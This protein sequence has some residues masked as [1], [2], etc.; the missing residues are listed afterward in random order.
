ME[1]TE[2][3]TASY[4]VSELYK[5]SWELVKKNSKSLAVITLIGVA[6]NVAISSFAV[7]AIMNNLVDDVSSAVVSGIIGG[8]ISILAGLFVGLLQVIALKRATEG[9]AINA[10]GVVNESL[11][12]VPRA[13]SYGLFVVGIFIAAATLIAL[14]TAMAGVLGVLAGIAFFVMVIVALF[15][16]AFVQFLIVEPK[17]MSFME[18]FTVSEKLTKGVYNTIFLVALMSIVLSIAGGIVGGIVSSP[19]NQKAEVKQTNSVQYEFNNAQSVEDFRENFNKAVKENV[20]DQ[21]GVK[22]VIKQIITQSISWGIGLIVLG[23]LLGL[24]NKR[25]S[26]L[27]L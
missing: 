8:A 24:Y 27:H 3:T 23:A 11:K 1:S 15:R 22:Y 17:E 10:S 16:Y 12:F 4:S 7:F 2:H 20:K 19:F 6:V 25:K 18:R 21:F 14:L 9:K 13:A 5:T 26:A